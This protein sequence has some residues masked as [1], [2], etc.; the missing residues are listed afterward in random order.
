MRFER[1]L[2][3][4]PLRPYVNYLVISENDSE[5]EYRVLPGTGL[6]AGFQYSG[7]LSVWENGSMKGLSGAGVTGICDSV[8]IFRNSAGIGTILIYFTETGLS[9]FSRLPAHELFGKSVS[10]DEL[11]PSQDVRAME[12]RLSEASDDAKRIQLVEAFLLNRLHTRETDRLVTAGIRLLRES[13]GLIRMEELQRR[14][15]T[16]ASPFE[17][18][19]RERAGT[20]PK[21]L[22]SLVRFE[23]VIRDLSAGK[24]PGD[25]AFDHGYFDQAHFIRD[26]KRFAGETPDQ[27]RRR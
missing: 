18:R 13:G 10:L 19:F 1:I 26:F 27:F 8:R 2:P 21:R 5:G 20:S 22:A 25:V 15:G 4:E 24:S 9:A 3:A 6:V 11:F 7:H 14:L 16:S 23:A 17:K 12:D